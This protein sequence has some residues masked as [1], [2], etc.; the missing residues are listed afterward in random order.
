MRLWI[1]VAVVLVLVGAAW[2]F[3]QAGPVPQ[4]GT[5]A[6]NFTLPSQDG[7]PVSLNQFRGKWVVLYFYPKDFSSGCTIEAHK[8]QQDQPEYAKRNAVVIGVSVDSAGSHKAFCAKEGL[9]FKLLADTQHKVSKEYGS[10]MNFGVQQVAA[11]HTFLINPKGIIE[12]SYTTVNPNDHSKEVLA[13]LDALQKNTS[14]AV[15]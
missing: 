7:T 1:A 13:E 6:P 9:N 4:A 2:K 12:R 3:A 15:R 14:A 5:E 10:L 11:R 8:F